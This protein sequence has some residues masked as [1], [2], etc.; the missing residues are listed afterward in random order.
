MHKE[1][2][3]FIITIHCVILVWAAIF[4]FKKDYTHLS[5]LLGTAVL[6]FI[7]YLMNNN[8][9]AYIHKALKFVIA[10]LVEL[11]TKVSLFL[12]YFLVV[13]PVAL[14]RK[15]IEGRVHENDTNWRIKKKMCDNFSQQF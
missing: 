9:Y 10:S 14:I 12:L 5:Y 7:Y 15:I 11:I 8:S 4:V 13:S 6:A 1:T 3:K 2:K